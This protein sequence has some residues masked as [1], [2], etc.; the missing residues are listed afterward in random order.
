MSNNEQIWRVMNLERQI[1]K[2]QPARFGVIH[3][4][5]GGWPDEHI[6]QGPP[7]AKFRAGFP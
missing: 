3:D 2:L 5:L 6:M 1:V 4:F 7:G